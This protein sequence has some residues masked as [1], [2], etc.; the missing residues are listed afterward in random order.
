MF[1]CYEFTYSHTVSKLLTQVAI[2]AEGAA[3]TSLSA[4][5]TPSYNQF[6]LPL[7]DG[8]TFFVLYVYYQIYTLN[9]SLNFKIRIMWIRIKSL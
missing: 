3:C 5:S 2:L 8:A 6:A 1:W 7:R 4:I 9:V